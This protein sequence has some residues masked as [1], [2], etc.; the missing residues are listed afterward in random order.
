MM[1]GEPVGV[2]ADLLGEHVDVL[3]APLRSPGGGV[4]GEDLTVPAVDGSGQPFELT[5]VCFGAML[6]ER[7]QATHGVGCVDCGVDLA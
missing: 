1:V 5:D 7:D 6:K 4:V 3:D 2:A